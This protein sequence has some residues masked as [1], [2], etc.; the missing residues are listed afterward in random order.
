MIRSPA[1]EHGLGATV[2]RGDGERLQYCHVSETAEGQRRVGPADIYEQIAGYNL[3]HRTAQRTAGG[4]F[5]QPLSE[6]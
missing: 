5:S 6:N 3:G 1:G 4:Q 2:K